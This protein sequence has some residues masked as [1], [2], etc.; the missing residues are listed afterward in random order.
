MRLL[1]CKSNGALSFSEFSGRRVPDYAILSHTWATDS[2]TELTYRDVQEGAGKTKAG[3]DKVRF[4]A[5][6]AAADGLR[7][8][9][10]DTCCTI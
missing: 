10:I 1:E 8:F 3:Y 9:W 5:E 2:A 6:Q 4:C 7:Y